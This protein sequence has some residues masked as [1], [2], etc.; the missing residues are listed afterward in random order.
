M[1]SRHP[2]APVWHGP[3]RL[4]DAATAR[5]SV[6]AMFTTFRRRRQLARVRPGDGSPRP[7]F[8]LWQLFTRTLFHLD[9]DGHR[10]EVDVRYGG[11][12]MTGRS[13]VALYRDGAQVARSTLPATFDVPGG[14][15][16]VAASEYGLKRMHLVTPDGS[17]RVLTPHPGTL[18]GRRA[19]FDR[20]FPRLSRGLGVVA[21]LVALAAALLAALRGLE[22][23]TRA[24]DIAAR[25]GTVTL[26]FTL[27]TGWLVAI[28]IAAALA[29]TER[30]LTFRSRWLVDRRA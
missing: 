2:Q 29:A 8:R 10:Y 14:I 20:R 15:V 6:G 12:R 24:P 19:A 5:A 22:A 26:P 23:L 21:V 7:D 18:E 27:S 9:A 11:D 28:G 4:E 1:P 30:A 3:L 17:A 25:V 13:P 16:E